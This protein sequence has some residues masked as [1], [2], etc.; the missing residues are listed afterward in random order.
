MSEVR[1]CRILFSVNFWAYYYVVIMK[2]SLFIGILDHF[3]QKF[4]RIL[5]ISIY[6][7]TGVQSAESFHAKK[8]L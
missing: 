1:L 7:S 2:L 8:I 4:K 5:W 3:D 6:Y